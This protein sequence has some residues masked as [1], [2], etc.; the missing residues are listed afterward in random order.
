MFRSISIKMEESDLLIQPKVNSTQKK[1]K[2]KKRKEFLPIAGGI[3]S[4]VNFG[5]CHILGLL[6]DLFASTRCASIF[7]DNYSIKN[8]K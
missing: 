3:I 1:K 4:S 2:E 8:D 5:K 7:T 6:V